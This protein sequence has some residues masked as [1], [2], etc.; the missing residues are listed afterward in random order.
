M[1]INGALSGQEK[2][3]VLDKNKV[4][5]YDELSGIMKILCDKI[6]KRYECYVGFKLEINIVPNKVD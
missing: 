2:K 3:D 1:G 5:I 6:G 4:D